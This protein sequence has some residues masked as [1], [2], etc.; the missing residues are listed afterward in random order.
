[1]KVLAII[2]ARKGSK[3]I[4]DKNIHALNGHPLISYSICAAK[5]I[6]KIDRIICTTDSDK[7]AAIARRYGAE[8]P[9]IRPGK[10]AKDLSSDLEVFEHCLKWLKDN[11]KYI[12]DIIVHLRP[13]SPIRFI[14]DITRG[15]KIISKNMG[16]DSVRSV[17]EPLT[18]PYKMWKINAKGN[19]VPLLK[20]KN[21]KEPYNTAR[22]LLPKIYAQTGTL[23][24]LRVSTILKKKSMT[25]NKIYP[26]FIKQEHF[27]DIDKIG[28]LRIAENL[29]KINKC[30][31][32]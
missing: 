31:K 2:P 26:L 16:I 24:I 29:I 8:T 28:S 21:N 7:I 11:E 14:K 4:K 19:L 6:K 5:K 13:T 27:V 9:F 22:Q 3:G 12:P 18:T 30:I 10:Y 20:I 15:I 17:S 1:M 25:G 32:P 23:D